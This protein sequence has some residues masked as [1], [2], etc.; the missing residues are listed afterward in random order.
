M[1]KNTIRKILEENNYEIVLE[2]RYK[3]CGYR[4]RTQAGTAVFCYD[5]GTFKCQ[6]KSAFAIEMLLKRELPSMLFNN[7]VFVVYGHDKKAKTDL[8]DLLQA[9]GLEPLMIDNLPTQGRTIIEQLEKY[10]PQANFGI[11]LATPDDIGYAKDFESQKKFRARQNVVLELGMLLSKLGRSR[12]AVIIKKD[13]ELERPSDI[14]GI[15]YCP[16]TENILEI[17]NKLAQELKSHGYNLI[18]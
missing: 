16:Y 2:K 8:N 9:W 4:L 14:D 11:V 10:I 17:S 6:G 13:N 18:A 3:N 5:K 12:V 1:N 7:K 15:M